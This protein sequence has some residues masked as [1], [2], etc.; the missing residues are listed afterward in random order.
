MNTN[1]P[2]LY[3]AFDLDRRDDCDAL[4]IVLS[5]RDLRLEQMGVLPDD[6]RRTQTVM[7][8]SVLN[9]PTRRALYDEKLDSGTPLTWDQ[10]QHLGNFGTIPDAPPQQSFHQTPQPAPQPEPDT[11]FGYQ[12]GQPTAEYSSPAFN[13][14]D[15]QVHS[16]MAGSSAFSASQVAPFGFDHTMNVQ[17]PTAGARLGMAWLDLILA[18]MASG[19][20]VGILGMNAFGG[21]IVTAL[22]MIAYVVGSETVM[23]A[24]P[25]KKFFG[26]EVRDVDTH[27]R[28]SAQASLKR[29]WWKFLNLVPPASIVTLV[30]AGYYGSQINEENNM[31]GGHDK[32]ANAEVVKKQG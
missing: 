9:D 16:S 24:T 21:W 5:A 13:P 3:T 19:I 15:Q 12:F 7:A 23:G 1:L 4:G 29:N 17:R 20:I 28:L 26:Y 11:T 2:N 32:L 18:S 8:F 25:A 6:P 30:M 14:F 22:V 31:R 27:S 10:I